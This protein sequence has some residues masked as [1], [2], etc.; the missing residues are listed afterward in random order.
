MF[1][2]EGRKKWLHST[3]KKAV[4]IYD[5]Y[6]HRTT[7]IIGIEDNVC[8]DLASSTNDVNVIIRPSIHHLSYTL[9]FLPLTISHLHLHLRPTIKI[10][11][12]R[13]VQESTLLQIGKID[14]L[15]RPVEVLGRAF[16]VADG[17]PGA[18]LADGFYDLHS[19]QSE[20]VEC[21]VAKDRGQGKRELSIDLHSYTRAPANIS[22]PGSDHPSAQTPR[23]TQTSTA[24]LSNRSHRAAAAGCRK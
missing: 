2:L 7:D 9:T 5:V 3:S 22:C 19:L 23:S 13:I 10:V 8:L 11:R 21:A 16:A 18:G 15:R 4:K 6:T 17:V 1:S 24:G 20:N 14:R 12:Q